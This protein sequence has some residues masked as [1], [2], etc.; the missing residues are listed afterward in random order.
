MRNL[1]GI[2]LFCISS[3][4]FYLILE[5]VVLY[6]HYMYIH[7][8]GNMPTWAIWISVVISAPITGAIPGYIHS[9]IISIF[10]N[11]EYKF[12]FISTITLIVII[13]D[14]YSVWTS[15]ILSDELIRNLISMIIATLA[16]FSAKLNILDVVDKDKHME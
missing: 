7:E 2:I 13:L 8:F 10:G 11:F 9:K 4:V 15:T 3:I 5:A 6:S 12:K 16:F 1:I 14:V